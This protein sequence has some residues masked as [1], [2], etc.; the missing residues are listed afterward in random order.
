MG[1]MPYFYPEDYERLD[2][3]TTSLNNEHPA[4]TVHVGDFKS[5]GSPC[6][7]EYFLKMQGYFQQFTHPLFYTPGDNEWTDCHRPAAGGFVANERLE[8]VREIFY[9]QNPSLVDP[10]FSYSSQNAYEGYNKF[11][12][13]AIWEYKKVTFGTLHVVGSNNNFKTDTAADNSEFRERDA[14]NQFWLEK[15]FQQ[16]KEN[17]SEGL[18]LFLHAS[19]N[20]EES[21]KNGFRNFTQKLWE[22][23]LGFEKPILMVYGDHHRFLIEKPLV[24]DKGKVV[25]HF[26]SLMV[27][28]DKDMH[29]VEI[30]V[31]KKDKE[32]FIISQFFV[33][34]N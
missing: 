19:L 5:G 21:D 2:R 20:Y 15:I 25:K 32:L 29:A 4:F 1:D 11:V 22:E 33:E 23:V 9:T 34:G 10:P 31:D 16:A 6:S 26:T 8:K 13:N 24:D 3:L 27:F 18:A 14:A 28:G 12:E 30:R 17:N 7:D